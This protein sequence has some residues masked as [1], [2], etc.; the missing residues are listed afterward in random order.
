MSE[1]K[2]KQLPRRRRGQ[3]K[4]GRQREGSVSEGQLHPAWAHDTRRVVDVRGCPAAGPG[5]SGCGGGLVRLRFR[6]RACGV[7]TER[8]AMSCRTLLCFSRTL[9][10]WAGGFARTTTTKTTT[11]AIGIGDCC[12]FATPSSV[13]PS[14]APRYVC[15]AVAEDVRRMEG[16]VCGV[17]LTTLETRATRR[18]FDGLGRLP[19]S[20][21]GQKNSHGPC[22]AA[23]H[24]TPRPVARLRFHATRACSAGTRAVSASQPQPKPSQPTVGRVCA[25]VSFGLAAGLV[26]S[27]DAACVALAL[28]DSQGRAD[29]KL[30][31]TSS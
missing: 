1:W 21:T 13:R 18:F 12:L 27:R 26:S 22:T 10:R 11:S 3:G 15:V 16:A 19:D 2:G 8:P 5:V 24:C 7:T 4:R 14:D 20:L 25:C 6:V 17:P 30:R 29:L 23:A 9:G 28:S 31:G